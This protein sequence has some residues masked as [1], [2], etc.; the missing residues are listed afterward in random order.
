MWNRKEVKKKG[1]DAFKKN[2]GKCLLVSL[3]MAIVVG[4]TSG[5]AGSANIGD[6]FENGF[7]FNKN[8]ES[9]ENDLSDGKDALED[10]LGTI[11]RDLSGDKYDDEDYEDDEAYADSDEYLSEDYE[12][13][14]E[15]NT[16]SIFA[17]IALAVIVFFILLFVVVVFSTLLQALLINP[18]LVGCNKF[19]FRN[20]NGDPGL[21]LMISGFKENYGRKVKTLF[22]R[23]LFT[24]FWSLL[25]V[26]PGIIKQYEYRMIPFILAENPDMETKQVFELSRK[27]MSG[28]KW[29]VFVYD[30][31]FI[32][33]YL[34]SIL[35]CGIVGVAYVQPYKNSADAAIY[36]CLMGSNDTEIR[37]DN[38]EVYSE[39]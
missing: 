3:L 15:N 35:T 31:S 22:L 7:S 24:F 4:G 27:L 13:D 36:E 18:F 30:L 9:L 25:L 37:D 26:F 34:L 14:E 19:F 12:E 1:N 2:Y 21:D 38:F 17:I 33:W 39:V 29:N 11:D 5:A 10:V 6:G 32:G 23:D 28:N 16:D 20:L 8:F